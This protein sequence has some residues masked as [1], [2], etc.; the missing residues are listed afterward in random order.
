MAATAVNMFK[1]PCHHRPALVCLLAAAHHTEFR[2]GVLS[3][4]TF[5]FLHYV[6]SIGDLME[7]HEPCSS[8]N[9]LKSAHGTKARKFTTQTR[10]RQRQT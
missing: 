7:G 4:N 10:I 5:R 1:Q 8:S 2:T 9:I 3:Q 6:C